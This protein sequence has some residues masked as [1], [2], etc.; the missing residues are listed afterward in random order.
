MIDEKDKVHPGFRILIITPTLENAVIISKEIS[1]TGIS[2]QFST[3]GLM[4]P[5]KELDTWDFDQPEVIIGTPGRLSYMVKQSDYFKNLKY[6][7]LH[8][9]DHFQ[10]KESKDQIEFI[11]KEISLTK[12]SILINTNTEFET[13]TVEEKLEYKL[14]KQLQVVQG[15]TLLEAFK[16]LTLFLKMNMKKKIY[17]KLQNAGVVNYLRDMLK[18][19]DIYCFNSA[20]GVAPRVRMANILSFSEVKAGCFISTFDSPVECDYYIQISDDLNEKTNLYFNVKGFKSEGE[21]LDVELKDIRLPVKLDYQFIVSM[22]KFYQSKERFTPEELKSSFD[23][24][25]RD[26]K[27]S[28]KGFLDLCIRDETFFAQVKK[29]NP[30][31]IKLLEQEDIIPH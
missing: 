6:L 20:E 27:G 4:T 26:F 25:M 3:G 31:F 9:L 29:L 7:V 10:S 21:K 30:D 14:P 16:K 22:I 12:E 23:E 28:N 5:R 19:N 24:L 2:T 13:I 8:D 17:V 1:K 18:E 11:L 15:E